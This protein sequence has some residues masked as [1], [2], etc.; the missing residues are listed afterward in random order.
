MKHHR[1]ITKT[2]QQGSTEVIQAKVDF[3]NNSVD[4]LIR[5]IFQ[6]TS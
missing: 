2:P 5:W 1:L 6:K 4:Q 3:V